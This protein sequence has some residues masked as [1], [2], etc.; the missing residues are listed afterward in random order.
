MD[1]VFVRFACTEKRLLA[2]CARTRLR[3]DF[4]AD[5]RRIA[6]G[7]IDWDYAA[8][9]A[10]DHS[11]LSLT[12]RNLREA[13]GDAVPTATLTRF[14]KE[15][16][17]S[18]MRCLAQASELIRVVELLASRGIHAL[19]YKGPVIAAQAYG[20]IAARQFEDLDLILAQRDVPAADAAIRSTGYQPRFPWLHAPETDSLVPGE[21]NYFNAER[22]TL[23]E[24][25]TEA[26]LRHFPV[27]PSL[28]DFL[29]RAACVSLGGRAVRTFRPADALPVYCIHG[30]KDFWAKL[31]WI[32]DVAE[33]LR[34]H[35]GLDWD[36]VLRTT[37]Q[38]RAQ[39]MLHLGLALAAGVL[40]AELPQE[41]SKRV[42]AD[43][44]AQ[45]MA[46]DIACRLLSRNAADRTAR[47]RFSFRR[48]SV[49]GQA[50]GW[51]YALRLTFAPAEADWQQQESPGGVFSSVVRPFRLLR[52]YGWTNRP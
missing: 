36:L 43:S 40:D 20:D 13:A 15:A 32:A 37:R 1:P 3:G 29:D 46:A 9:Q 24:L 23:L 47:E 31:I 44:R 34:S 21:Y 33:L 51:R 18:A 5:I 42:K 12:E 2:S 50:A 39:R 6:S 45:A 19:P 27:R 4:V 25:H 8:A 38:L 28:G 11:V 26:T 7:P 52:K 48:Y 16:R 14:E 10:R 30:A 35:A 41:I 22:H 17:A 49:Q